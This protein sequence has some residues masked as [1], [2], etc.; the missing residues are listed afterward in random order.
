MPTRDTLRASTAEAEKQASV[1]SR[2][3]APMVFPHMTWM[4][5][6]SMAP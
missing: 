1:P 5:A 2:S 3:P 6:E 4:P